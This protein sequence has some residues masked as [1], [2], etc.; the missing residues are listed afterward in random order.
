[1]EIAWWRYII[2]ITK[3]KY[4]VEIVKWKLQ[5]GMEIA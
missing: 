5:S 4:I 2:Q 3:W 1:M